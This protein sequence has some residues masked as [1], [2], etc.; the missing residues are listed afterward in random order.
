VTRPPSAARLIDFDTY[1][2]GADLVLG[3]L[4]LGALGAVVPSSASSTGSLLT[5][6][7]GTT[8]TRDI[9]HPTAAY[10]ASKVAFAMRNSANEALDLW[11]V[12]LDSA[13]TC[14]QVTMSGA[15]MM[16]G[17][18]SHNTDPMY[19]PDGSLVF[20]STRG[21]SGPTRSLKYF[22]PQSD[23][24]RLPRQGGNY[25]PAEQLTALL[26]SELSPF[27]MLNGQISFTA[28]K[29]SA[30]FYQLSGRRINWDTTDYHPLLGQRSQSQGVDGM[31]HPSVDYQQA[32]EIHEGSR[33]PRSTKGSTATSSSSSPT[34]ARTA[35]AARWRSSTVRWG[36]SNRIAP[37]LRSCD[38]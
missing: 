5:H 21:K 23:L 13:Q 4:T 11:E 22:L 6:C 24:W 33:R 15:A 37:R 19:A 10:D 16:N 38:R 14:T 18:L 17:M 34:T 30:D 28:E 25:G 2:P 7:P 27:M 3:Q 29:A 20:A 32:T 9:R 36:R 31:M 26:G 35:R 12:T 8:A 1:E